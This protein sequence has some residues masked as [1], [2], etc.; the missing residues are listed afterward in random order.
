VG[1]F[2]VFAYS[3]EEVIAWSRNYRKLFYGIDEPY[4]LLMSADSN[5]SL[6]KKEVV[7]GDGF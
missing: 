7:E 4:K 2:N 6:K 5:Q 3:L 1:D